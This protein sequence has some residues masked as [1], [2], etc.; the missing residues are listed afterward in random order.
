VDTLPSAIKALREEL[1]LSQAAMARLL[2][3]S[4]AGYTNYEHGDRVPTPD[5]LIALSSLAEQYSLTQLEAVFDDTLEKQ[6]KDRPGPATEQE[7]AWSEA[8]T[9][10][11]RREVNAMEIQRKIMETLTA[12]ANQQKIQ[13]K[14]VKQALARLRV[15]TASSAEEKLKLLA[16]AHVEETGASQ[17]QAFAYVLNDRP[18]LAAR[19]ELER[20]RKPKKEKMGTK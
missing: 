18:E 7:R 10:L 19:M 5:T 8:F 2:S 15:A 17:A 13:D 14:T 20:A 3:L 4:L 16:E 6:L 12:W 1:S 9:Q 11:L